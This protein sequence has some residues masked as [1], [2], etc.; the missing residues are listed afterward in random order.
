M[1][2]ISYGFYLLIPQISTIFIYNNFGR[3]IELAISLIDKNQA[4]LIHSNE[5]VQKKLK[6]SLLLLTRTCTTLE[7]PFPLISER[8]TSDM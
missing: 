2:N 3:D 4:N 8:L 5:G 1:L 7:I 6:L